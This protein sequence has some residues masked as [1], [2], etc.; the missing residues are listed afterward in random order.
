MMHDVDDAES[1]VDAAGAVVVAGAAVSSIHLLCICHQSNL[2]IP[3]MT[4]V[5]N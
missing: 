5:L 4:S 3:A 2:E 1:A